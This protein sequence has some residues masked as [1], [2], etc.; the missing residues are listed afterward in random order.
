MKYI[1]LIFMTLCLSSLC[2]G[3]AGFPK[4]FKKSSKA[5]EERFASIDQKIQ[6][7]ELRLLNLNAVDQNLAKAIEELSQ[8]TTIISANYTK[9]YETVNDFDS[10]LEKKERSIKNSLTETKKNIDTLE[11]KLN[12]LN[13][14]QKIKTDLQNQIIVLLAQ[15]PDIS[16][17][18][19]GKV[20]ESIEEKAEYLI[21][22][23]TDLVKD[24]LEEKK[25]EGQQDKILEKQKL[26]HMMDEALALYRDERYNESLR[27]WN[28]ILAVDGGNLEAKFNIGIIEERMKSLSKK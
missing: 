20:R 19:I 9:L 1:F 12:K 26:Q 4:S 28:E 21:P 3:C 10:K 24:F 14:I 27:K 7:L 18:E 2:I 22:Q 16:N 11:N 15:K 5:K 8:N 17:L 6:E 23:K 13:E 25:L